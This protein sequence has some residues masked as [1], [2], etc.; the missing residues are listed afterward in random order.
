MIQAGTGNRYDAQSERGQVEAWGGIVS[1]RLADYASALDSTPE[2]VLDAVETTGAK[3]VVDT[4][5]SKGR[6]D[7]DRPTSAELRCLA[8]SREDFARVVEAAGTET[9]KWVT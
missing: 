9:P 5:R 8:F 6:E 1:A 2:E 7:H 3:P 4:A